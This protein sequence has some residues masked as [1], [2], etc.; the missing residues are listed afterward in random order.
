V[1]SCEEVT[2]HYAALLRQ[3]LTRLTSYVLNALKI[4]DVLTKPMDAGAD[5]RAFP[6]VSRQLIHSHGDCPTIPHNRLESWIIVW[7]RGAMCT[8]C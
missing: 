4:P 8:V 2:P 3:L 6:L 7:C 1:K 5:V